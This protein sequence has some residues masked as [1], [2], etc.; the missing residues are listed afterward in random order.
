V[1]GTMTVTTF[2]TFFVIRYVW[3]YPLWLCLVATG[4][5]M[6]ID[7]TFFAAAL[8][9]ILEGGWFPLAL[10]AAIFVVMATWR[11][12]RD[13][14]FQRLSAT[15]VPLKEFMESLLFRPPQR[16]PGN[17]VFL[18]ALPDIT[19][20]SLV[21]SLKHYKVLHENVVF[22]TVD[23][24]DIPWVSENDRVEVEKLRENCH[25]LR[26][27][28]G[29]MESPDAMDALQSARTKGLDLDPM[30]TTFFLSRE[31]IIPVAGNGGMMMWRERMFAAMARNAGN[32]TDYFRIPNN[33]VVELGT[34][35]EL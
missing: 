25:R 10:G 21:H 30:E 8:H 19:P 26:I 29:F 20:N 15:A 33:R 28:Y 16:V 2:L 5:F 4:A 13:I 3:G 18:A 9:K 31:K 12:G 6:L 1:M 35:I 32:I 14:L 23:F 17:A 27:R 22:L 7:L 34:R 11:R 24:L